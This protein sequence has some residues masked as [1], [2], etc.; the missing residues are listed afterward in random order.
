M[1]TVKPFNPVLGETYEYVPASN[2]YKSLCEQVRI[3]QLSVADLQFL[4]VIA[5]I[6]MP[7]HHH[8]NSDILR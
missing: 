8:A 3:K 1:F 5:F 6:N 4:H 7:F 2:A